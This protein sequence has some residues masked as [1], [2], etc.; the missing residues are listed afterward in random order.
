[1]LSRDKIVEFIRRHRLISDA[2]RMLLAVSGGPDSVA[3]LHVL[4]EI[5]EELRLH[6]EVAHLEHGIRGVEAKED[7]RFVAALAGELSI[8]FHVREIDLPRIKSVAGKGNL[9]ALAR[10]ERHR[11]FAQV[12][13]RRRLVKV[14]TAHTLDDQ[15]ETVLMW[16][17]RGAGMKGLSGIA[18]RQELKIGGEPSLVIVRPLLE[19]TKAEV[20]QFL[21][22]RQFGFRLDRTNLDPAY[23]RNWIRLDLLPLVERRTGPGTARRLSQLAELCRDEDAVLDDLARRRYR[24]MLEAVK[25]FRRALLDQPRGLQ[26]R[27]LRLWIEHVRGHL[28][29]VDFVHIEEILRLIVDG[30]PQARVSLPG[31]WEFVR[32]YDDLRLIKRFRSS[33]RVCYN[34]PLEI[35]RVLTIPEADLQ[36]YSELGP[37]GS[38]RLPEDPMDAVFDAATVGKSLAVRNFRAGD[39]FKPVGMDGHKKVKDLFIEKRVPL[40]IRA[41]WPL[42]T[43][44]DEIVW[45]PRYGRSSAGL[46]GEKTTS[47]LHLKARRIPGGSA[48]SHD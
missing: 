13:Q 47:L 15:A 31:G 40:S 20:L 14:A 48:T 26:R 33:P 16:F 5:R 44:G 3:L 12:M 2:D 10:A 39:R 21:Q 25:P 43:S 9:E 19:T 32:E 34:Y 22:E 29:G 35:G 23:L 42:V 41:G 8:P 24:A 17:L 36:M 30:T 7:A 27:I 6:L 38:H 46:V 37:P 1:V 18:P 28:R 45:I 11:F 4:H